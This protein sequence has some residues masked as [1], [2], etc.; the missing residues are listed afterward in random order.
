MSDITARQ[1]DDLLS[2]L[3]SATGAFGKAADKLND[4]GS[5]KNAASKAAKETLDLEDKKQGF[6][7][8]NIQSLKQSTHAQ[9]T[10]AERIGKSSGIL[11]AALGEF[12]NWSKETV[13]TYREMV[14]VGQTFNGS[15]LEM[16]KAAA[17][18]GM[19]LK[20]FAEAIKS[21]SHVVAQL[22]A[23]GKSGS[24]GDLQKKIRIATESAGLFGLSVQGLTAFQGDYLEIQRLSNDLDT[25]ASS[26][27]QKTIIDLASSAGVMAQITGE[28]QDQIRE[29]S[30]AALSD[31]LVT[32]TL[33][34]NAQRGMG[35]YNDALQKAV[36]ELAAQPGIAGTMLSKGMADTFSHFGMAYMT[37]AG[38]K[39]IE[40]GVSGASDV[41]G[42]AARRISAGEDATTVNMQ[43]VSQ[44]KTMLSDPQTRESLKL[45]AVA[46]NKAAEE[47]LQLSADLKTYTKADIAKAKNDQ[48]NK[49]MITQISLAGK[50]VWD[51]LTG[52]FLTGF[53]QP[54]T[55][56]FNDPKAVAEWK[57]TFEELAK[58]IEPLGKQFGQFV[59]EVF[60]PGMV[61]DLVNGLVATVKTVKV[62]GDLGFGLT[63]IVFGYTNFISKITKPLDGL[64]KGLGGLATGIALVATWFAG[65]KLIGAIMKGMGLGGGKTTIKATVANI[66]ANKITGGRRGRGGRGSGAAGAMGDAA[67]EVLEDTVE[68]GAGKIGRKRRGVGGLLKRAMKG[69]GTKG[70]KAF[71]K[72]VPGAAWDFAKKHPKDLIKG[73]AKGAVV[74]AVVGIA[75]DMA[76]EAVLDKLGVK[77]DDKKAVSDITS[78]V[79]GGASMG[80]TIGS[81]IPG[82]GTLAGGIIGGAVGGLI[83]VAKNFKTVKKWVGDFAKGAGDMFKNMWDWITKAE[84]MKPILTM[85]KFSPVGLAFMGTKALA[86][87]LTKPKDLPGG[88]LGDPDGASAPQ[89]KAGIF[90][91]LGD[92][93]KPKA[94]GVKTPPPPSGTG[95]LGGADRLRNNQQSGNGGQNVS[96]ADLL[97]EMKAGREATER[98]TAIM[99][100]LLQ[101]SNQLSQKGISAS[102]MKGM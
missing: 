27:Y 7:S 3:K 59:K 75:T 77:G 8:K 25:R 68:G 56:I 85:L 14:Q 32:A 21:N 90:D 72:R 46:G 17:E 10:F 101:Q 36:V 99:S 4:T 35:A 81:I 60:T 45:Q 98:Q 22:G 94:S 5:S 51:R 47:I 54:I 74:G 20:E 89:A 95:T 19:P 29:K 11:G 65:K 43:M 69:R 58:Q 92:F 9:D 88:T 71:A 96:N 34:Q 52:D 84:W 24:F 57:T 40:A 53:L 91:R 31:S 86:G 97:K 61:K 87:A 48:K 26:R 67:E 102:E 73:A 64:H 41:L 16:S 44:L 50:S 38:Q 1:M 6:I 33:A 62:I 78:G 70:L 66:F 13:S 82:V 42:E 30:K 39:F 23:S 55:E 2:Q 12:V 100:R 37:E 49:D 79:T 18:S 83:G 63:K 93:F 76:T 80:A 28:A 15:M